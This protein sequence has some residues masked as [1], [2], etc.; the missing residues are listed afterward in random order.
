MSL[1]PSYPTFLGDIYKL[2]DLKT[3]FK[4]NMYVEESI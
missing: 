3:I 4:T 1:G 2:C